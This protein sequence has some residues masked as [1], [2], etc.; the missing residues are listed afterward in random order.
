[1]SSDFCISV[2]YFYYIL[3]AIVEELQNVRG[4]N[5]QKALRIRYLSN[6][7]YYYY[8]AFFITLMQSGFSQKSLPYIQ[9]KA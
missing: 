5:L 9:G 2:K 8:W 4:I 1:M 7:P 3:T 6:C